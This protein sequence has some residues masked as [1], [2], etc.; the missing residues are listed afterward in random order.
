MYK[1]SVL[2]KILE[3]RLKSAPKIINLEIESGTKKHAVNFK[4]TLI[5]GLRKNNL[6]K[7]GLSKL[8][9]AIRRA[10]GENKPTSPLV[11][12]GT[13]VDNLEIVKQG[14][15][16][17]VKPNSKFT[18]SKPPRGKRG[19]VSKISIKRLWRIHE[20]GAKIPV[21]PK[22]RSAF[23]YWFNITLRKNVLTIPARMPFKLANR[24]YLRSQLR[25]ETDAKIKA[26]IKD[27][28]NK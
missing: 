24:R 18:F 6:V 15:K 27:R 19:K 22:M 12:S 11:V 17:I 25:K 9:L 23:K 14:K 10:K 8:S 4:E 26:A 16:W 13:M 7:P 2:P 28:L 5:T 1:I 3:K 21:T 20:F